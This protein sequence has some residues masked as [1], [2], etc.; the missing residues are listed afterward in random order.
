MQELSQRSCNT[1]FITLF[2][3]EQATEG[4][5]W[6]I[7]TKSFQWFFLQFLWAE[8][9]MWW[10]PNFM[11]FFHELTLTILLSRNYYSS[12]FWNG[13]IGMCAAKKWILPH[14]IKCQFFP[15]NLILYWRAVAALD[16]WKIFS[17]LNFY[18]YDFFQVKWHFSKLM[19]LLESSCLALRVSRLSQT[20]HVEVKDNS[21]I[22]HF[23]FIAFFR[24]PNLDSTLLKR[25]FKKYFSYHH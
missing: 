3:K 17:R 10:W 21:W 8:T 4:V 18:A 7:N 22:F 24:K 5:K 20:R 19:V 11:M 6:C 16:L 15:K 13:I 14:Q 1:Y 25:H 12:L 23:T 2:L 9:S